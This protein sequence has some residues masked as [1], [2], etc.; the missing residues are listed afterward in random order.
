[1]ASIMASM[2]DRNFLPGLMGHLRRTPSWVVGREQFSQIPGSEGVTAGSDSHF[3]KKTLRG[4]FL[5]PTMEGDSSPLEP[6][7]EYGL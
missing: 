7:D 2:A 5:I 3:R 6:F 1:M 4:T